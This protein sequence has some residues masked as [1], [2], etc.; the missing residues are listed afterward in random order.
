MFDGIPESAIRKYFSSR[1]RRLKH[2]ALWSLQS[3]RA[4]IASEDYGAALSELLDGVRALS[5][6]D[7]IRAV[8]SGIIVGHRL[9][10]EEKGR[11]KRDKKN[12]RSK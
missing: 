9:M 7:S 4:R 11:R 10:V 5:E 8:P 1:E 2:V 3:A 6:L 12:G